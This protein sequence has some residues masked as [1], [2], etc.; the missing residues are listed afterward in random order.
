VPR[1]VVIVDPNSTPMALTDRSVKWV[2][3]FF[4]SLG[5]DVDYMTPSYGAGNAA[6]SEGYKLIIVPYVKALLASY[7]ALETMLSR[8]DA[9]IPVFVMQCY[10]P[11]LASSITNVSAVSGTA[12]NVVT[13]GITNWNS[14]TSNRCTFYG[15]FPTTMTGSG[16]TVHATNGTNVCMWSNI[17]SGHATLWIGAQNSS[18]SPTAT[19]KPYK[20]WLGAQWMIDKLPSAKTGMRKRYLQL[21][22]DGYDDANMLSAYTNGHMDTVYNSAVSHGIDEIWLAATW[23]GTAG[24]T[25]NPAIS[26]WLVARGEHNDG[27]FRCS[28]HLTDLV[29][30]TTGSAGS[31]CSSDGQLFDQFSTA[32]TTYQGHCDQLTALGWE[33]GTD[34]YGAGYP[35][36][37]HANACNNPTV[38]FLSERGVNGIRLL[39][40]T[41]YPNLP[42]SVEAVKTLRFNSQNWNGVQTIISYSADTFDAISN[43]AFAGQT[44]NAAALDCLTM[45]GALYWHGNGLTVFAPWCD[46]LHQIYSTCPDVVTSGPWE[47][48]LIDLKK[49]VG[50]L[51]AS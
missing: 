42:A 18:T 46:E 30:G 10:Q 1:K 36:V 37:Q 24:V 31:I 15:D 39:A 23:S 41:S 26:S 4:E 33:L 28:N 2:R 3:R 29:D 43:T 51:I 11:N 16:Y 32:L 9:S 19:N 21:W 14:R 13:T 35:N 12:A 45:G 7:Q 17:V 6:Y 50:G 38:K 5:F 8:F 25:N 27:L 47:N 48:M 34:G 40:T 22:W 44:I 20:P 49:G